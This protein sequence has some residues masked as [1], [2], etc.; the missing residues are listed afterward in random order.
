MDILKQ[1][2][3][4]L[5]KGDDARVGDPHRGGHRRRSSPP[6]TSCRRGSSRE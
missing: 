6:A 1:I 3:D 4:S 2:A 5:E